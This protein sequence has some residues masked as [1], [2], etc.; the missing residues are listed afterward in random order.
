ML[1]TAP[2]T[3]RVEPKE[4][5]KRS[6]VAKFFGRG[7]GGLLY[8]TAKKKFDIQVPK[9]TVATRIRGKK[10]PESCS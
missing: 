10:G 2:L 5:R 7:K 8:V 9:T 4:K 6:L 3:E 1:I